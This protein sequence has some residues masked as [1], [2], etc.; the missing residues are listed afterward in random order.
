[1]E[2]GRLTSHRPTGKLN[3]MRRILFAVAAWG[4]SAARGAAQQVPGRDLLEFPVGAVVEPPALGREAAGG[5]WNPAGALLSNGTRVRLGAAALSAPADQ[6]VSAQLLGASVAIP[7]GVTAS[8]AL[9]RA[10]VDD[11]VRTD[12]DP[13]SIGGDVPYHTTLASVGVARRT[14]RY[15]TAGVALRYRVGQLDT[16]RADAVGLDGGIVADGF[17]PR[18][19][20]VGASTFLWSPAGQN[21]ERPTYSA[22]ADFRAM[23]ASARNEVRAGYAYGYTIRSGDEHYLFG[24]ARRRVMEAR[25]GLARARRFG[26]ADWRLRLG[27]GVYYARYALS[28]G[29]EES[30]AGLPPTYQFTLTTAIK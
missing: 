25:A 1:V 19:V 23:G 13:Q 11:I 10:S 8:V 24:S 15:V 9:V 22:A 16:R 14:Q 7:G 29:R 4:V 12:T 6:A 5:L 26:E 3:S 28:I 18:D 21:V 17:L 30:G 20:R 27:V 2:A